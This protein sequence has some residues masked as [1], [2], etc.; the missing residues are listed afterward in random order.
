[1]SED[2]AGGQMDATELKEGRSGFGKRAPVP[3]REASL[4]YPGVVWIWQ[5]T[6]LSSRGL[7]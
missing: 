6:A 2:T 3:V 5:E 4:E 1:M 7:R